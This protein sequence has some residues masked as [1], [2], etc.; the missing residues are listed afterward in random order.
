MDRNHAPLCAE[1]GNVTL[2]RHDSRRGRGRSGDGCSNGMAC[3]SIWPGADSA[4]GAHRATARRQN[5][6][7]H[8]PTSR[9]CVRAAK[10]MDSKSI[11]LCPQ[12]FESL[13]CRTRHSCD[14][15]TD[16]RGING[17]GLCCSCC[18]VV[19][20]QT[21]DFDSASGQPDSACATWPSAFG[22]QSANGTLGDSR[23]VLAIYI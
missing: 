15:T 9:Q 20:N 3:L 14:A 19:D 2:L 22:L 6:R 16:L 21:Q 13:R 10:E 1:F 17:T 11:G 18:R 12:G 7:T 4:C 5:V 23:W 8:A